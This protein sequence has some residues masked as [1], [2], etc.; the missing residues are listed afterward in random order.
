MPFDSA[1]A[2][3]ARLEVAEVAFRWWQATNNPEDLG[4]IE[5]AEQELRQAVQRA[6][7]AGSWKADL[8]VLKQKAAKPKGK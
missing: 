4:A 7:D 3:Q 6:I 1:E 2:R 5:A 8:L